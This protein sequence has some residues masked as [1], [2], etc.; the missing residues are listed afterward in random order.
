MKAVVVREHGGF[1]ALRFEDLPTPV[2]GPHEVRVRIRAA[3]LNALDTWVRRGVPGHTF[4]L[5]LVPGSDGAG[6]VD[7]VGPGVKAFAVGDEVVVIPSL[8]CGVCEPCS[9]GSDNL[10]VRYQILGE[11]RDGCC[12]EYVVLPERAVWPKPSWVSFEDAAAFPL[13]FMTAWSMLVAKACLRPG[14]TVL[15]L[16]AGS[17]VGSA[18]I[19]IA[20][21]HGCRVITTV[22]SGAK[23]EK[24]RALGADHVID[25]SKERFVDAVRKLTDKRG[26]DIVFEHVGAATFADSIK[27]L[28][29][30][31]RLVTCGATTGADVQINLRALF[32]KNLALIGNTM[33]RK[34]DLRRLLRLFDQGR[35]R[36][37]VDRVLPMTQV[38]EAHRLLETR[39]AFGKIVLEP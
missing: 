8:S 21:L 13:V 5:P 39:Q 38:G 25:H 27:C 9:L 3:G 14:E 16:A 18:A 20:K 28:V 2:P 35:L 37:V 26:V 22:G 34:G 17:G 11:T 24:A 30:G 12:A 15:V 36:P 29:R 10:C 33:G 4:P 32:F 1:E 6:V 31:G 23:V 7:A 19:Q